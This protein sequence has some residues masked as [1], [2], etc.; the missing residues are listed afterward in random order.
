MM[1]CSTPRP[2]TR[3]ADRSLRH[4]R[5][6]WLEG[7]LLPGGIL[8]LALA[9]RL[10]RLGDANVE[11]D[12]A[13]AVWATRKGFVGATLWTAGDAHPPLYYWSLWAWVQAMGDSEFAIR[14]LFAFCGVL[15]V[16]IVYALGSRL[17]DRRTGA[18]AA[19]LVSLARFHIWWSQEVR[20]YGLAALLGTLSVYWFLRWLASEHASEEP[21]GGQ[22]GNPCEPLGAQAALGLYA[23]AT[24]GALFTLYLMAVVLVV[25]NVI[26]ALALCTRA[27]PRARLTRRWIIVQVAILVPMGAW[28]AFSWGRIKTTTVGEPA[29]LVSLTRLY[30]TLLCSGISTDIE[31]HIWSTLFPGLVLLSGAILGLRGLLRSGRVDV[32]HA[33]R[34]FFPFAPCAW[35]LPALG[36]NAIRRSQRWIGLVATA[37]VIVLLVR[38]LPQYYVGRRLTDEIQTMARAIISQASPDDAV[39]LDSGSRLPVF[40][41]Y[42][43]RVPCTGPRPEVIPISPAGGILLADELDGL[44]SGPVLSHGRVWLAEVEANITDPQRLVKRWFEERFPNVL[45]CAYGHNTLTLYDPNQRAPEL[46]TTAYQ[47]QFPLSLTAAD[48]GKMLG[49]ELA[50]REFVP[51][52]TA[53]VTLLWERVPDE[54]ATLALVSQDDETVMLRQQPVPTKETRW[55]QQIDLPIMPNLSTGEYRLIL[56]PSAPHETVLGSL[57]IINREPVFAAIPEAAVGATLGRAILLEGCTLR[58]ASGEPVEAV[59]PGDHVLLDL[60]WRAL[61]RIETD[62]VV[63]VHLLGEQYNPDTQ[64]PVWGQHDARPVNNAY[65]TTQWQ[66]GEMI[67]DRHALSLDGDAPEGTYQIEVGMYDGQT[68][69]RLPMV[70]DDGR[71]FGDRIL[72]PLTLNAVPR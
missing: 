39:L 48:E 4:A 33:P 65:P 25:Q 46:R 49:W 17:A 43:E 66:A 22:L 41:Y 64:G 23:L 63:F 59:R 18:I 27:F 69:R 61:D 21:A 36:L 40:L 44:L 26:V 9:L 35:V 45:Y 60:Q 56:F 10:F 14:A 3:D 2:A 5:R 8:L 12:E 19:L 29:S 13:L 51:G 7:Y 42:Y 6:A 32:A 11:W 37:A 52:D 71:E 57:K 16:A 70:T 28:L 67:Y 68:G 50:V 15:T 20:M 53:R 31:R 55:R 62:L 47:P 30:V 1:L 54:P 34:Y 24:F 72:L 38:F 58:T